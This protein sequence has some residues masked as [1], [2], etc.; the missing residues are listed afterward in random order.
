[1]RLILGA[2]ADLKND[3]KLLRS[4][5]ATL[6]AGNKFL[7]THLGDE[8]TLLHVKIN[9]EFAALYTRL[10]KAHSLQMHAIQ[11]NTKVWED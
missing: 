8:N 3:N 6:A 4:D 7:R 11:S 9:K 10:Q 1:M 5:I 2:I